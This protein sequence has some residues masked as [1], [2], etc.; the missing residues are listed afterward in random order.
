MHHDAAL[1]EARVRRFVSERLEPAVAVSASPLEL[2]AWQ[3]PGE[4][5]P[6]ADAVTQRFTPLRTGAAWGP[7]WSTL[8]IRIEGI[9]PRVQSGQRAELL[10]DLGFTDAQPGFQA[11]GTVYRTDGSIVK[12]IEPRNAYVPLDG[13]AGAPI[14]LYLE[15][16]ANPDVAGGWD[17]Q[18]TALG[19]RDT[20]G[21]EPLYRLERADVVVR[22]LAAW[23]LLQDVLVLEGLMRELPATA[24]RRAEIL[25]A[26]ERMV[27]AADP[28]D[29]AGTI[30]DA[31][32]ELAGVLARPAV[33]SA[34]R[35]HAVG[36]AHIDSAWL[37]PVRETQRKIARTFSNV[38][39][40]QQENPDFHFAASSAQQYAWIKQYQPELFERIREAIREGR[41]HPAG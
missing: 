36:H 11:E 14:E 39:S 23:E 25:A 37:W 26:L 41:F 22:D 18:P 21:D 1:V 27:D 38:L 5:V 12:A 16:A 9:V 2:S 17:F 32:R 40:L 7:A 15:A 3:A 33:G 31:R 35:V 34:H 4:P 24:P 30:D 28:D 20:A 10:F 8:W 19:D 6:F 13:A 29:I